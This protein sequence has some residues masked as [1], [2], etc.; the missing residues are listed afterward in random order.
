M[1]AASTT[2]NSEVP[3]TGIDHLLYASASLERGMQEIEALL[4]VRPVPGGH[5]PRYG[6][7]NALLSLGPGTYLEVIA[8]DPDLAAPE[9]GVL[10]DIPENGE[11]RLVTWVYRVEDIEQSVKAARHAGLE[12]GR[13]EL[14]SRTSPDGSELHWQ[15]TDPYAVRMNGVIPFLINW[16]D[17]AHPA[18]VVPSGG[19]LVELL[20]EH[21]DPARVRQALA[22]LEADVNVAR[23]DE[24]RI[25]ARISTTDG[26]R[27]IR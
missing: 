20:I 9:R 7:H 4:G 8:R 22:L 11:S 6:T 18:R 25:V 19:E 3:V 21:P 23:G 2:K 15:V 5:H 1:M 26:I 12:L 13:I 16:G 27:I 17:T 10:I 14:G 24:I